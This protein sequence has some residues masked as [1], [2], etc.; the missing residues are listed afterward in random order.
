MFLY[1]VTV[2]KESNGKRYIFGV[3]REYATA[4]NLVE[5]YISYNGEYGDYNI[6]QCLLDE[7]ELIF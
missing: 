4:K 6:K 5:R 7:I 3:F 1:V 2:K